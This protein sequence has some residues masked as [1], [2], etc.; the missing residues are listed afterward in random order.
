MKLINKQ[1]EEQTKIVTINTKNIA[2]VMNDGGLFTDERFHNAE[3]LSEYLLTFNRPRTFTLRRQVRSG[4]SLTK[5]TGLSNWENK[6]YY[7][8][9]KHNFLCEDT[10]QYITQIMAKYDCFCPC[11]ELSLAKIEF[12]LTQEKYLIEL[13]KVNKKLE[14]LNN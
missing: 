8:V 1:T 9:Y 14:K 6:G 4:T 10:Q 5:I 11:S 3:L 7:K 2:K 12:P 13:E